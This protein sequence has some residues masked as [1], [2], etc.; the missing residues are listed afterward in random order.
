MD[1]KENLDEIPVKPNMRGN[2]IVIFIVWLS[3][4]A[5]SIIGF[6]VEFWR[7]I[8]RYACAVV[9]VSI[10]LLRAIAKSFWLKLTF[11]KSLI[12]KNGF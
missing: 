5:F 2:I 6:G 11:I 1:A 12:C 9:S 8:Y 4:I 7:Q 10:Q 3:G